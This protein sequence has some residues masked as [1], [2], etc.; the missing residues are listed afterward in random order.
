MLTPQ[1]IQD[2]K[3]EKAV[4]GGYDMGQIDQ[5]LDEV[6]DD[7]T[8]LYKENATLKAKMKVLVDKIE[9]YHAVDEEMRK[10]LYMAQKTSKDLIAKAEAEAKSIVENAQKT[11][12]EHVVSLH[13][14]VIAEQQKLNEIQTL[15][16]EYGKKLKDALIKTADMVD[17]IL[18]RPVGSPQAATET[19]VAEREEDL[20]SEIEAGIASRL[21]KEE[22]EPQSAPAV[23]DDSQAEKSAEPVEQ[24]AGDDE[25]TRLLKDLD[26]S[27][28]EVELGE[29]APDTKDGKRK[30]HKEREE[31]DSDTAKIYGK[32]PFTPKPRFNFTDLRFGKDYKEENDD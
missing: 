32:S 17:Q 30:H 9:E 15:S 16:A 22:E 25:P 29:T 8:A 4:F 7:Y 11:A 21:Q 23:P 26:A 13:S 24:A 12:D 5:F 27:F 6:L 14:Q 20:V 1:E 10:A 2:K 31:D 28:F 18:T 19:T 3:F